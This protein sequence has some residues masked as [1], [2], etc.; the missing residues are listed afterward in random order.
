MR[1]SSSPVSFHYKLGMCKKLRN[2]KN[3]FKLIEWLQKFRGFD[4]IMPWDTLLWKLKL[5]KSAAA[6]A[7]SRLHAVK[8]KVLVLASGKDNMLPSRDE[9]ERF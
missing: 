2:R 5:L 6:Y 8:A 1:F 3:H 4:D 7:Y 9:A